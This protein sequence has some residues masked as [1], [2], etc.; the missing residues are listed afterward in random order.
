[1]K[2]QK[3]ALMGEGHAGNPLKVVGTDGKSTVEI[4]F[5]PG[6]RNLIVRTTEVPSFDSN[7]Q[8]G[9]NYDS[10]KELFEAALEMLRGA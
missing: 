1:M 7:S 4:Y 2:T 8:V 6:R 5:N 10:A 3:H 9:I